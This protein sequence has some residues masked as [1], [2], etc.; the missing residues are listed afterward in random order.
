MYKILNHPEIASSIDNLSHQIRQI[1]FNV[2]RTYEPSAE[3]DTL[4]RIF[5]NIYNYDSKVYVDLLKSFGRFS[6]VMTFYC[7]IFPRVHLKNF[8]LESYLLS[9]LPL[10]HVISTTIKEESWYVGYPGHKDWFSVRGSKSTITVWAPVYYSTSYP[11]HSLG[12]YD[13]IKA[14]EIQQTVGDHAYELNIP[15]S[16]YRENP[17]PIGSVVLFDGFQPHKSMVTDFINPCS[18]DL[19]IAFSCRYEF[20]DDLEFLK[21]GLSNNYKT[22]VLKDEDYSDDVLSENGS[23]YHSSKLFG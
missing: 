13:N 9:S 18:D 20:D 10:C 12:F 15:D 22:T 11:I 16:M 23:S 2:L 17:C 5:R 4:E 14:A 3:L 19:R 6:Q 1:A 21:R 8:G 7:D